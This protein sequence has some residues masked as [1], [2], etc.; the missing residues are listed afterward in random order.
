MFYNSE[1]WRYAIEKDL[2]DNF[3]IRF[4]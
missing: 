4:L 1:N 3:P 2:L